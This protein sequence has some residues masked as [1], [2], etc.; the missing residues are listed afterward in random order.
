[1]GFYGELTF[2]ADIIHENA[3]FYGQIMENEGICLSLK[4][5]DS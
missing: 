3:P 1:M 4:K 2:S 5:V